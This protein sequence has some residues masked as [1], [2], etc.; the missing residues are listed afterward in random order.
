MA[1]QGCLPK[2]GHPKEQTA[3]WERPMP[4]VSGA[5]AGPRAKPTPRTAA[6]TRAPS[7]GGCRRQGEPRS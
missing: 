3:W 7:A 2:E 1:G 6:P 4:P 5:N